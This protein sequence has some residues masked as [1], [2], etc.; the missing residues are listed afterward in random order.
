MM[1]YLI[2]AL[3]ITGCIVTVN[4]QTPQ[5]RCTFSGGNPNMPYPLNYNPNRLSK[6]QNIYKSTAF[7]GAGSGNI[8][9]VYVKSGTSNTGL[10]N[11][12]NF[13]IKMGYIFADTFQHAIRPGLMNK[14][15]FVTGLD[16]VL[17]ASSYTFPTP[18]IAGSW[19]K[20]PVQKPFAYNASPERNLVVE[21][22]Q[23]PDTPKN[24]FNVYSYNGILQAVG[25]ID[26]AY[27]QLNG[28]SMVFGFDFAATGVNELSNITDLQL[29]PN[30]SNGRFNIGF[31]AQ[32]A[33]SNVSVGITNITGQQVYSGQYHNAG[34]R[35]S[36]RLDLSDMPKGMYFIKLEADGEAL[37]RKLT[38][39]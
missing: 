9:N 6:V 17:Y 5:F 28:Q 1:R 19:I 2:T 34:N 11:L 26:S 39:E 8:I 12:T 31:D 14:T 33:V 25:K 32:K 3:L 38:I 21:I 13:T 22:A 10:T 18:M 23:G 27:G 24:G 4:A 29:Y 35:F 20:I 30:P 15:V 16:T 36:T 37:N 7:P